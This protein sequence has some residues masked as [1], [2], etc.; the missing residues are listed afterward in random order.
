MSRVMIESL[1]ADLSEILAAA[2]FQQH[3]SQKMVR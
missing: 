2:D 1:L 3:S